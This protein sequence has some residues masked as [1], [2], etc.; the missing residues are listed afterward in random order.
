MQQSKSTVLAVDIGGTKLETALIAAD[1]SVQPG[2]RQRRLTGPN[3]DPNEIENCLSD[4]IALTLASARG[5]VAGAGIGSAGPVDLSVG[6]SSPHNMPG[7]RG[8]RVKEIVESA[9]QLRATLRLDGT[10]IA[11]AE[12]WTGA[13]QGYSTSMALVV[14]TGVGG[15]IIA[16]GQLISGASGNAGH[17]GQIHVAS[18]ETSD[19]ESSTLEAVASGPAT[20]RWARSRGWH[21]DTGE[22]LAQAVA[23]GDPIADA[24]TRR[25]AFFVGQAI[26]S[27]TT[28][29]DLE[30]VAIGGGFV[31]VRP[32]YLNLVRSSALTNSIF[33]YAQQVRIVASGHDGDGPLLGAAALHYCADLLGPSGHVNNAH[34]L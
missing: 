23:A 1:G 5:P 22:E 34:A 16:N 18:D 17:L 28:L 30:A 26:A 12:F 19:A 9:A 8:F 32:D 11:L 15:G 20:V 29:L 4:A 31:N 33:A 21:G 7:L 13:T 10:C 27:A 6:T 2:S 25:S 14:S 24:A 3:A